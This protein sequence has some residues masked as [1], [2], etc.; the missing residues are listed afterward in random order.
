MKPGYWSIAFASGA[1]DFFC[2]LNYTEALADGLKE[3]KLTAGEHALDAGSGMGSLIPLCDDWLKQGGHLV[4]MDVDT[5]GLSAT[6]SRAEA[7]GVSKSVE[8]RES[9]FTQSS[10]FKA[11]EF[12][13]VLSLFSLYA[14]SD[15]GGRLRTV[16]NFYTTLKN[17]GR[18]VL[19]VPS[20]DYNAKAILADS[21]KR[22]ETS[23]VS[24]AVTQ[25]RNV[26][27]LKWL[28]RIQKNLDAGVFHKFKE[29]EIKNLLS[30][31]GFKEIAIRKIYAGNALMVTCRK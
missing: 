5:K 30:K 8:I 29:D 12:D 22:F 11:S 23:F 9:D 14:V 7:L 6:A 1:Y 21:R 13:A 24:K 26:L 10:S 15:E 27:L 20:M 2:P 28:T 17:G 25:L 31:V 18:L 3:A 16:Q 19:Q 4:C